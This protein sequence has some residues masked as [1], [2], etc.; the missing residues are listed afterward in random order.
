MKSFTFLFLFI[1]SFFFTQAQ[2]VAALIKE[3][4]RIEL[5]PNE[6]GAFSK[7]KE[8]LL[9]Q[10][11]NIYVLSKCSELCSRIG[12]RQTNAK[13]KQAYFDAALMYAT[14]AIKIA[15]LDDRANVSMAM[16][17]GKS[18]MGKSGKEKI[19]N[20]KEIKRLLDVALNTNPGN[21]LAWHIL[22]R[23]N[24]EISNISSI[25]RAAA[26]VFVGTVPEGSIKNAIMYL[27]KSRTLKPHFIL[28]N[29]ELARAYHKNDEDKKAI[30]ILKSVQSFPIYT[31]DD[32][33]IKVDCARLAKEWE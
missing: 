19:K 2:D 23:W 5:T 27:E 10:P 28:N 25:E 13:N 4:D 16:I 14:K 29:Y 18:S 12:T 6:T 33:K 9:I 21:Y 3:A 1:G 24:Y 32:E 8:I 30:A 22:G 15:P 11:T 26:K 31:E 20:A 17:L 7:F